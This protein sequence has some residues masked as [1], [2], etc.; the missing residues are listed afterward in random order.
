MEKEKGHR[1]R[2]K[3]QYNQKGPLPAPAYITVAYRLPGF[4]GPYTTANRL[5]VN[6][7]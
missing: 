3:E 1:C 6:K 4:S 7:R 5:L 2:T